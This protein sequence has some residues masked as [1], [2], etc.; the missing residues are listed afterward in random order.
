MIER[1]P[2]NGSVRS[3][4]SGA[5]GS[6]VEKIGDRNSPHGGGQG[7]GGTIRNLVCA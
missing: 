1:M 2:S 6:I 7:W 3:S 5:S 4:P